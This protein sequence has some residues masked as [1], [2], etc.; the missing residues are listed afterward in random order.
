MEGK[1]IISKPTILSPEI[2]AG[3]RD[4]ESKLNGEEFQILLDSLHSDGIFTLN[5]FMLKITQT[6]LLRYF[7]VRNLYSWKTRIQIMEKIHSM[8]D[9]IDEESAQ[10]KDSHITQPVTNHNE[11]LIVN[12]YK[13]E[14]Y[15]FTIP[16]Q[17]SL[18]GKTYQIQSWRKLLIFVCEFMIKKYP[19]D[20]LSLVYTPLNSH[21]SRLDFLKDPKKGLACRLL[22]N[23]TWV[24][25]NYNTNNIIKIVKSLFE[26]CKHPLRDISI[27]YVKQT[28][29]SLQPKIKYIKNPPV[30]KQV[31]KEIGAQYTIDDWETEKFMLSKGI[32]GCS[33]NDIFSGINKPG[34]TKRSI[35]RNIESCNDIVE[36][37]KGVFVH[38]KRIVDFDE[39]ADILLRILKKQFGQ[40][41]GYS[42]VMLL[43]DAARIDLTLFMNDNAFDGETTIYFLAKHLFEKEGFAGHHFIFYGNTHI[44]EKQPD[45]ELSVKGLLV[46]Q[47][48][49]A[50]GLISRQ[51]CEAYFSKIKLGMDSFI[52]GKLTNEHTFYL[53]ETGVY[54]L[55]EKIIIDNAW[56]AQVKKS[57]DALFQS[58]TFVIP[59]DIDDMWFSRFPE[60]PLRFPWTVLLLQ[61]V[62]QHNNIGYKLI[63]APLQQGKDTIAAAIVPDGSVLK[64]FADVVFIFL[65]HTID[66]P[67]RMEKDELHLMLRDAG[68]I[69]GNE[70]IFKLHKALNDYRFSWQD[71]NNKVFIQAR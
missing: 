21:S 20:M 43:F 59:R 13:N 9:E 41:D 48:R 1:V 47:A 61:E 33:V 54:L 57:L 38:R 28:R 18:G 42:N 19:D 68:I 25:T 53:Y 15:S 4:L 49:L 64:T 6:G 58:N 23:G 16:T 44:W 11:E 34:L 63:L 56:K 65:S 36:I 31:L 37:S 35:L 10:K 60:L 26:Y 46:H 52:Q 27:F 30:E 3:I 71:N 40:F 14:D 32:S 8:L 66:L 70:L 17:V 39:A 29:P 51:E 45:Y 24:E 67:I 7:N 55:A 62:L 5:Q 50:G 22:S 12:F 2:Q 69:K